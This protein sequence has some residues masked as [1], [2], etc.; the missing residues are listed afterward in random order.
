M[1]CFDQS[2]VKYDKVATALNK[3]DAGDPDIDENIASAKRMILNLIA[4]MIMEV[5]SDSWGRLSHRCTRIK[6]LAD[7][8]DEV[9]G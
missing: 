1:D 8:L 2:D 7:E 4:N 5:N 3:L 6:K 9:E